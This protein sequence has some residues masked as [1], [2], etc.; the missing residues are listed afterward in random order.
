MIISERYDLSIYLDELNIFTAPGVVLINADI[1]EAIANP[2]PTCQLDIIVPLG[3]IDNRS[4]ADGSKISFKIRFL[5]DKTNFVY[6]YDF[7]LFDIKR[8]KIEQKFAHLLISGVLD[9]YEGY[10]QGNQF[11]LY[12]NSFEIVKSICDTY[13]I[14]ND[15]DPTEDKQLWVAGENNT[16]QF[17]SYLSQYAWKNETS[18]YFWCFDKERRLLYK[19]LSLLFRNRQT[20]IFKFIQS[21]YAFIDNHEFGYSMASASLLPGINNIHNYGYGGTEYDFDFLTYDIKEI[22]AKKVIAESQVI[23]INK[24]LSKGLANEWYPFDIGN[25]HPNYYTAFKQNMRI[26]STYSSYIKLQSQFFQ[27]YRLCQ[28]VNFE[29]LD[30]QNPDNK[31]GCLSGIYMIDAIRTTITTSNITSTVELVMQGMNGNV[32]TEEVY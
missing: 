31:I 5:E 8:L 9:F 12:A 10:Q 22:S 32:L 29:Y 30:A 1:Y 28:I 2:I 19:D 16:Y 17:I 7:R 27:P 6:E 15:I 11:N 20:N 13:N 23:N 3:W 18:C 4:I 24:E 21:P 26:M 14:K 25:F